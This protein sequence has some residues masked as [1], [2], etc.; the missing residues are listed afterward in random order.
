MP[1]LQREKALKSCR[2]R[3]EPARY[4]AAWFAGSTL[5]SIAESDASGAPTGPLV[6]VARERYADGFG[7]EFQEDGAHAGVE[8]IGVVRADG[9]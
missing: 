7:D 6:R 3:Y 1:W 8:T 2:S 4:E 9:E 5:A